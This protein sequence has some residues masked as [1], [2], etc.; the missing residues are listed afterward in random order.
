[1]YQRSF[2]IFWGASVVAQLLTLLWDKLISVMPA[3][4]VEPIQ[5][6]A[7]SLPI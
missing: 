1:M 5:V 7:A 2:N 3:S 4:H 6:L